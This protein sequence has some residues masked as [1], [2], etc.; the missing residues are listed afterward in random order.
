VTRERGPACLGDRASQ[1]RAAIHRPRLTVTHTPAGV[2]SKSWF[3]GAEPSRSCSRDTAA[4]RR[5]RRTYRQPGGAGVLFRCRRGS[6]SS[7]DP[8]GGHPMSNRKA[9]GVD[10]DVE[11]RITQIEQMTLDQ[12]AAFQRRI[13]TEIYTGRIAP[14][15]ASAALL[16]PLVLGSQ[17]RFD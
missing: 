2:E 17:G 11:E 8:L 10:A 7:C 15:A 12:I 3:D 6:G 16:L 13:L 5:L 1:P 14:R 9:E 4:A